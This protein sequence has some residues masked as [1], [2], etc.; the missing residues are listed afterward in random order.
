MLFRAGLL[1]SPSRKAYIEHQAEQNGTSYKAKLRSAIDRLLPGCADLEDL[2]RRLQREGYELKRGKYISARAPGQERFTRLKTLGADYAE[3]ALTSRIAG[4][5]SPSRQP[6][7][8]TG[9][10]SLLIDIQNNIK[11]QQSAGYKHWATIE[12]LKRAA[13]TLNFLTEHGIGSLEDLSERCDG[14]AAAT[15]RVKADLRATKKEMERLTLTMKHAA[16]Y[17][18]LRPLYEEYRQSRDKEKF[19]RGHESEIILFEAAARE[20]KRLGAVPLPAAQRLRAEMDELT[21]RRTALQ[22]EYRK[23]QQKE[24]EYDTLNQN[25]RILLE[26]SE[27]VVLPKEKSNELE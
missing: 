12:N 24:R 21:A 27:D 22:S 18:Q 19:L 8:R 16:T 23:A 7:Q 9:R 20:L 1:R 10:P 13:E 5:P 3:E 25:V 11:A 6:K 26:R 15:A 14:A 17:R 2:L 4:K